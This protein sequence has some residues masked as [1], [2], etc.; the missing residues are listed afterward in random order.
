M[1]DRLYYLVVCRPFPIQELLSPHR[2]FTGPW[3]T[4]AVESF[5]LPPSPGEDSFCLH[6]SSPAVLRDPC[7]C[8][9]LS[10]PPMLLVTVMCALCC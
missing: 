6:P 5:H 1:K 9:F 4:P 8:K 2:N 7:K 3:N 10:S